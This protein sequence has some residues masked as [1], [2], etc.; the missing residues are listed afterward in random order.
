MSPEKRRDQ[1]ELLGIRFDA[2]TRDHMVARVDD[3]IA[4]SESIWLTFINV[5]I[6]VQAKREPEARGLL[7][8]AD[9]RL[10]DGMGLVYASRLLKRPLPEMVSGPYML[11]R[12]LQRAE[13]QH[14]SI[15]LLGSKPAVVERAVEN[16][17]CTYPS[18]KVAGCRSGYYPPEDES[19]VV[20]QIRASGAQLLFVGMGFPRERLFL[21][22][23]HGQLG[24][25][26]CMDVGGAFTVLA[27][28]HRLAP[29]WMRVAGLE[30][31]YRMAQ[32]PRRLW[33]R[34]LATNAWFCWL[35]AQEVVKRAK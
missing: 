9:Y 1:V 28:I 25:P 10:C 21:S 12:L 35:L 15:F 22:K 20:T 30:W 29:K 17:R 5:A 18:V 31:L 7:E 14:Y 16:I 26:V 19:Q 8:V 27:G 2:V 24:V 13:V 33:K 34:Y 4:A 23:Y 11:F 32:E 6:L 3:A